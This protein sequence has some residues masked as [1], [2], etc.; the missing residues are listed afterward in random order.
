MRKEQLSMIPSF[1]AGMTESMLVTHCRNGKHQRRVKYNVPFISE[2][3]YAAK[4][5]KLGIICMEK[6]QSPTLI[7]L[8]NVVHLVTWD[9]GSE[10]KS[11]SFSTSWFQYLVKFCSIL[12]ALDTVGFLQIPTPRFTLPSNAPSPNAH[13]TI[14]WVKSMY[15]PVWNC[16]ASHTC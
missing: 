10:R 3:P 7:P 4:P 11:Q 1:Q 16:K 8:G 14:S 2:D 15:L 13:N 5:Q 9:Q 6:H 12:K